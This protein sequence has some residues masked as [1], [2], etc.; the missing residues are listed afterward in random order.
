MITP[1]TIL[2]AN[3]AFLT[4]VGLT[5]ILFELASHYRGAG[6]LGDRF[7]GS[8]YTIGFLEAHG[9]AVLIGILFLKAA[10]AQTTHFWHGFAISV[11]LLLGGA[12]L[13]FW[14]SFVALDFVRPGL[15]ATLCHGLFLLA[16]S[17][18]YHRT[19]GTAV[20]PRGGN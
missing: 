19:R 10:R 3:A 13:L 9:L 18:A 12:N 1:K 11:H 15:A 16:E 5:Q 17:Y 7:T 6:P 8:P 14:H 4:A 2:S 20:T